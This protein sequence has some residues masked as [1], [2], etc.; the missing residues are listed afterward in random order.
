MKNYFGAHSF[1]KEV[2]ICNMKRT[3]FARASK[4]KLVCTRL[5]NTAAKLVKNILDEHPALQSSDIGE[6]GLGQVFHADELLNMGSAQI[7]HLSGLPYEMSKF[8]INRQ[9]GS[10][11]EVIHR[12]THAMMLGLYDTALAMGVERMDKYLSLQSS[13]STR[14]SSLNPQYFRYQSDIQR[15][16]TP[17]YDDIFSH[18]IPESI[19]N[20][21]PLCTMVQ[22][23]QNVCD[24]YALSRDELDTFALSSH[25]KYKK[26]Q[27]LGIYRDEIM[28]LEV[29]LPVFLEDGSVD[30][31]QHGSK[32]IFS[33][34]E[35]YR[36]D[37]SLDKLSTLPP[38]RGV[39]SY[40]KKPI[41]V[42]AGNCCPTND[43]IA[44]SILMTREKA[45]ACDIK[46]LAK[47]IGFSVCGVKPQIMGVGPVPAIRK[48][49]AY[50]NL[51][52]K[53]IDF[54]EFNE[55][56][57]AQVIATMRELDYPLTQVNLHG[58]SLAI[59]HPLGA[60]GVRL[61]GRAARSLSQG[62]G[63]YAVAAQCIGAGM[64]IATVLER[65]DN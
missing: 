1:V 12:V 22:T 28:P 4:G 17:D 23:A 21:S 40:A 54:I 30:F 24:M 44:A 36:A 46:S 15:C 29:E 53:D 63:R 47:I 64:G 9:C 43:G 20:S 35:C 5:D 14:I 62:H 32:T 27:K 2:V 7:A 60:T 8:E 31:S 56:F 10:S 33:V 52:I 19:Q 18:T 61:V 57:A 41:I 3:A 65:I 34:D 55:A 45:D 42:T 13:N 6:F 48:A 11:M 37:V 25:K 26:A 38:I 59:G 51:S 16:I 39:Q 49:L 58:G 50:A